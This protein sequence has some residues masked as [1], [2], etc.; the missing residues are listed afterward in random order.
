M[1]VNI[2]EK[3]ALF[4]IEEYIK[5]KLKLLDG[6][7]EFKIYRVGEVDNEYT[8]ELTEK[9]TEI[10]LGPIPRGSGASAV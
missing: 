5:N 2:N 3:E 9:E 1:I 4:A 6:Q 8:I 7:W 10:P